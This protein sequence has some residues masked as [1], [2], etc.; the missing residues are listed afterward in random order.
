VT[1]I[2][3][4]LFLASSF[5]IHFSKIVA[6][7]SL[8]S[9]ENASSWRRKL[10]NFCE[11]QSDFYEPEWQRWQTSTPPLL[12][13]LASSGHLTSS[14]PVLRLASNR[15]WALTRHPPSKRT[16]RSPFRN[17]WVG[18]TRR[19][20]C[21]HGSRRSS[22]TAAGPHKQLLHTCQRVKVADGVEKSKAFISLVPLDCAGFYLHF[23][24]QSTDK[25]RFSASTFPHDNC[26]KS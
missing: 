15:R 13:T 16:S 17:V 23:L 12:W 3:D 5:L 19:R 26:Q 4:R 22:A 24:Q 14:V 11:R 9:E 20:E 6:T 10:V 2:T 25:R 18:K 8:S 7:T 1:R 21:Y